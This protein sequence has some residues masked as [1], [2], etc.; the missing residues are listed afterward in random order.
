M[1]GRICPAPVAAPPAH[2]RG[3]LAAARSIRWVGCDAPLTSRWGSRQFSKN[4]CGAVGASDVL[5]TSDDA[6]AGTS[7]RRGYSSPAARRPYRCRIV[8]IGPHHDRYYPN[9]RDDAALRRMKRWAR[10]GLPRRK[11]RSWMAPPL[12]QGRHHAPS[13]EHGQ[14]GS[15]LI[16]LPAG[17]AVVSRGTG[18]KGAIGR[19]EQSEE[20]QFLHRIGALGR[21]RD[22]CRAG[23]RAQ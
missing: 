12:R 14:R 19:R 3:H 4:R 7:G 9:S 11:R 20:N 21:S 23:G 17:R 10:S 13:K 6:R 16:E 5:I 1:T 2:G 18:S 15:V 8:S 22:P